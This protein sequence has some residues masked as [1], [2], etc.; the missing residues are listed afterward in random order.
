MLLSNQEL[1]NIIKRDK[2]AQTIQKTW[3]HSITNPTYKVCKKRLLFEFS[4]LQDTEGL[5]KKQKKL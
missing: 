2:S 5:K 3:R 1:D 4:E